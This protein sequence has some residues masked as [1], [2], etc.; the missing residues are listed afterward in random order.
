MQVLRIWE[1]ENH[2]IELIKMLYRFDGRILYKVRNQ[3][4]FT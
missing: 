1:F 2:S 3:L 4:D